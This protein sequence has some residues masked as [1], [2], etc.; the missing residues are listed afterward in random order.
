MYTLGSLRCTSA[1][2]VLYPTDGAVL[3]PCT[4]LF[5]RGRHSAL[6]KTLQ[7]LK[8]EHSFLD[9]N[10]CG[11]S[12]LKRELRKHIKSFSSHWHG[13][14]SSDVSPVDRRTYL[15]FFP[16]KDEAHFICKAIV[17]ILFSLVHLESTSIEGLSSNTIMKILSSGE[18]KGEKILSSKDTPTLP[19]LTILH[20]EGDRA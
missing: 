10:A 4:R 9:A 6:H 18:E 7:G 14:L 15:V 12:Q 8:G 5:F 19:H 11:K 20:R 13:V 17:T 1:S 2:H 3:Y 16:E